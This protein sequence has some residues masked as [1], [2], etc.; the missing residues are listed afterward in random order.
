MKRR[1]LVLLMLIMLLIGC[2]KEEAS[3]T[4]Y[5]VAVI[6]M[7]QGGEYWGKMKNGARSARLETGLELE[8]MAPVEEGDYQNQIQ[9][10]KKAVD[11]NFDGIVIA[12]SNAVA[13]DEEI[14]LARDKGLKIVYAG[15]QTL[16]DL[17]DFSV[18]PDYQ[19]MSQGIVATQFKQT[20]FKDVHALI[21][22]SLS[23]NSGMVMLSEGIKEALEQENEVRSVTVLFENESRTSLEE[24]FQEHP[25]VNM[26]FA[27]DENIASD[28]LSCKVIPAYLIAFGTTLNEIQALE[29]GRIDSLVV[30]DTFNM[31]YRAVMAV[32]Q[33]LSG[34][35]PVKKP[36]NYVLVS[37]QTLFAEENQKIL[38]IGQ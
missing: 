14:R 15:A 10:I 28:M 38:F 26:V 36:V 4:P 22:A 23:Y 8:F 11:Q 16:S 17:A 13:L 1:L 30:V 29:Q 2:A 5:R 6:T 19:S 24:Y 25:E 7:E 3:G 34:Q 27:L 20:K 33:L 37:K 21:V 9:L 32:F 18:L 35:K 31:G 12:P